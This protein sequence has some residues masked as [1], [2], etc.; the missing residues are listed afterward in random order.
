MLKESSYLSPDCTLINVCGEGLLCASVD[1][2]DA[3]STETFESL[4]DFGW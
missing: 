2:V 1:K 3:S 4:T